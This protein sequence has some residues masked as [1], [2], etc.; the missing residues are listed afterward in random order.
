MKHTHTHT[1]TKRIVNVVTVDHNIVT[2]CLSGVTLYLICVTV[3]YSLLLCV[4]ERRGRNGATAFIPTWRLR[5]NVP[6]VTLHSFLSAIA[7]HRQELDFEGWVGEGVG[8]IR[9][10]GG[11]A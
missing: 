10:G 5:S 7:A 11:G 2:V 9:E 8:E 3:V 1:H 4:V 6:L